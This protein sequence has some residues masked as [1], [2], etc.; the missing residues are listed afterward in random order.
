MTTIRLIIMALAAMALAS[1]M[2]TTTAARLD[3]PAAAPDRLQ[4]AQDPGP[5]AA[6]PVD[7]ATAA[8]ATEEV[9]ARAPSP[10]QTRNR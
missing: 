5:N 6:E 4:P 2:R 9:S 1:C 3:P 7:P 8:A 10:H